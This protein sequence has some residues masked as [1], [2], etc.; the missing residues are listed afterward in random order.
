M[1]F[2]SASIRVGWQEPSAS[3]S[4]RTD[5]M[6]WPFARRLLGYEA[7]DD[8]ERSKKRKRERPPPAPIADTPP[9][10]LAASPKKV[11]APKAAAKGV[12]KRPAAIAAVGA[13][14]KR[15]AAA[16][17]AAKGTPKRPAAKPRAEE[18]AEDEAGEQ[19]EE[20]AGEEAEEETGQEAEEEAEEEQ[21]AERDPE[22]SEERPIEGAEESH[23]IGE[24]GWEARV[25]RRRSEG[26]SIVQVRKTEVVTGVPGQWLQLLQFSDKQFA[27]K[28]FDGRTARQMCDAACKAL[29]GLSLSSALLFSSCFFSVCAEV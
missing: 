24:T 6:D 28:L 22:E 13:T 16:K 3:S 12:A 11:A 29:V 10:W 14:K 2:K 18:E 20:E 4:G 9:P 17:A 1:G 5:Y 8:A 15:P 19:S 21:P 23:L 25:S 7:A 26:Y 27:E